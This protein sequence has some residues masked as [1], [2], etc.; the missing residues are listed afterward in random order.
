MKQERAFII[1]VQSAVFFNFI[2]PGAAG[3]RVRGREQGQWQGGVGR[4]VVLFLWKCIF[5][6]RTRAN[7]PPPVA[8]FVCLV[9]V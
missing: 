5:G 9:P 7:Y 8:I 2:L 6:L 3:G 1:I 4:V